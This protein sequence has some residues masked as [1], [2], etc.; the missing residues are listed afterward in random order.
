MPGA[1]G[2]KSDYWSQQCKRRGAGGKNTG[3]EQLS[4]FT[5]YEQRDRQQQEEKERLLRE[6]KVQEAML[7]I[8][9][10]F[11]KNAVIK[12]MS[13]LEGATARERNEQ[14]G[15]HRAGKQPSGEEKIEK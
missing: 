7:S 13:L 10:K 12:G 8:K 11:G 9:K 2:T 6:R 5:D 3:F 4:L 14:I 1:S 15:G